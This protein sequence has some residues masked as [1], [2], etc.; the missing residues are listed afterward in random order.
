MN[1]KFSM[2]W[3]ETPNFE[4]SWARRQRFADEVAVR[5]H[6]LRVE[7]RDLC[8]PHGEVLVV[9]RGRD[10]EFRARLP[11]ERRPNG[12]IEFLLGK[13]RDEI[14]VSEFVLRAEVLRRAQR[15]SAPYMCF[16]Y[17]SLWWAGTA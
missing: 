9:L 17:H 14:L 6:R 10:D 4:P 13:E 11:E 8:C 3:L 2:P 5:A 15:R 1:W 16:S 12:R 7:G